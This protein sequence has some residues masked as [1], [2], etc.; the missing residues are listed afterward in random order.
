MIHDIKLQKLARAKQDF[1]YIYYLILK[2]IQE[3][4]KVDK[5]TLFSNL[6]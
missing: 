4:Q 2:N 1:I 6:K 3:Y 5:L